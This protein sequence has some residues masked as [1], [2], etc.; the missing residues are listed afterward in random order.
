MLIDKTLPIFF[1]LL[2]LCTLVVG[3]IYWNGKNTSVLS[4]SVD[5][6]ESFYQYEKLLQEKSSVSV[7]RQQVIS[8]IKHLN[9]LTYLIPSEEILNK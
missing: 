3:T 6:M 2:C 9:E 1:F 7:L 5:N 8:N 4:I